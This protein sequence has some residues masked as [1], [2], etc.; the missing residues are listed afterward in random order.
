MIGQQVGHWVLN[1]ELSRDA[2]GVTYKATAADDPNRHAMLKVLTHDTFRSAD[3]LTRFPA[4]MLALRR[5]KHDNIITFHDAG[6]SQSSAWYACEF[7]EGTTL[8]AM[9]QNHT[10]GNANQTP[11]WQTH[12]LSYAVQLAR[13]LKHGHHRSILHRDL[14]PGQVWLNADGMLK[15]ANF[16]VA[17]IAPVAPLTLPVEP[18]GSLSFLAPEQFN[19]KPLTRKSDL[20][21]LGGVIY[22]VVTGR[23]PF[24]ATTPAEYLHKHCYMLPD[25]PSH[26]VPDLP[27]DFDDL[28]CALLT[29]DPSRRPSSVAQVLEILDQVRSKAERKNLKLFWPADPG[30]ASGPMPALSETPSRFND[31]I[32]V[33]RPL[34]SRPWVVIPAFLLIVTI[35]VTLILWPKPSAEDLYTNAQPLMQSDN[36]EDWDTAW[37]DYLQPLQERYPNIHQKEV[38]AFQQKR[39]DYRELRRAFAPKLR[40]HSSDERR[41]I[42][43]CGLHQVEAGEERAAHST[44]TELVQSYGLADPNNR[45]IKLAELGLQRLDERSLQEPTVPS[46]LRGLLDSLEEFNKRQSIVE[47]LKQLYRDNPAALRAIEKMK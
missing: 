20:Y 47:S 46:E 28:I 33:E 37:N 14:Q 31:E 13:A 25:R 8:E 11:V 7:V 43:E 15:V 21:A 44:W 16:G 3:F 18:F 36:P 10:L 27:Q 17:K 41:R 39:N 40:T 38:A 32:E 42:Y 4:E 23:P 29:K 22:A 6:V 35:T 26:Y 45:W 19:G 9:L 30:D 24:T 1:E 12:G 5:L 34:M 2:T